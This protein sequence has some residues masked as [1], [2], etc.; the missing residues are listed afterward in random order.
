MPELLAEVA[1]AKKQPEVDLLLSCARTRLTPEVSARIRVTIQDNLDWMA[2]IWLGLR[3][4]IMPLLYRNLQEV[5]PYSVPAQVL[6]PLRARYESQARDTQ[7]LAEEL[8][9]IMPAL[10]AAGVF[11]VPWKGPALA[12]RLYGDLFLRESGDLDIMVA[13]RDVAKAQEVIRRFS[14]EFSYL[15]DLGKLADDVQNRREL[16]FHRSDGAVLELQWRFASRWAC[17]KDDPERFLQQFETVSVA[18]ATVRSLPMETYLLILPIHATKHKW[19]QLKLIC[20]IAE[21]LNHTELDWQYVLHEARDLGLR[22]MIGVGVVLAETLLDATVPNELARGLRIDRTTRA[23]AREVCDG[24]FKEKPKNWRGE[25]DFP[26]QL[27]IRERLRDRA[28]MLYRNLPRKLHPDDRDRE[29]LP[30][31]EFL[32]PLYY[33]VRPVRSTLEKMGVQSSSHPAT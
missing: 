14:Y 2:L 6:A 17:V 29:F 33:L 27:K 22:R 26:F 25:A 13:R 32:S 16:L 24:L 7:R 28:T 30:M 4:N 5:C 18:G 12:Q 3:H 15:E 8:V 21:I 19:G 11:A 23:L 31:P 1:K 9:R 20:D 10:D